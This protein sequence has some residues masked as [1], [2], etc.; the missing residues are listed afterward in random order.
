MGQPESMPGFMFQVSPA[1]GVN[2]RAATEWDRTRCLGVAGCTRRQHDHA[3]SVGMAAIPRRLLSRPDRFGRACIR[4]TST[5]SSRPTSGRWS[6]SQ[7]H[8]APTPTR[9]V[10]EGI[11]PG[12]ECRALCCRV[13]PVILVPDIG[14]E[15]DLQARERLVL[16]SVLQSGWGPE[17]TPSFCRRRQPSE[18]IRYPRRSHGV[19][20]PIQDRYCSWVGRPAGPADT[21][22]CYTGGRRPRMKRTAQR[23]RG[24]SHPIHTSRDGSGAAR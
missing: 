2:R 17:N 23:R 22:R 10:P 1:H 21:P 20:T 18:P 9:A 5:V 3:D 12:D 14:D 11:V 16:R 13:G 8:F 24:V 7:A 4:Q 19:Q 15:D 6:R